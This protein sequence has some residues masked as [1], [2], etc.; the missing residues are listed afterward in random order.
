MSVA[1][2]VAQCGALIPED[3][4]TDV[5]GSCILKVTLDCF[6]RAIATAGLQ[7]G[8]QMGGGRLDAG[9]VA[10]SADFTALVPYLA[11]NTISKVNRNTLV[12]S[13]IALPPGKTSIYP[14]NAHIRIGTVL[15]PGGIAALNKEL[16][17]YNTA[18]EL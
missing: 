1:D 3:C 17:A 5:D 2:V 15:Q 16:K 14:F 13:G 4:S 12:P 10:L 11:A 7:T 8:L 18:L 9:Q 6:K